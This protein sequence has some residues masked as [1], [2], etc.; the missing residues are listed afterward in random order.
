LPYVCSYTQARRPGKTETPR[1]VES[2]G[3][4]GALLDQRRDFVTVVE[5]RVVVDVPLRLVVVDR[6]VF[7]VVVF[8][9]VEPCTVPAWGW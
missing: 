5:R 7:R 6:V 3:V 1:Q 8:R 4:P 2:R 9:D